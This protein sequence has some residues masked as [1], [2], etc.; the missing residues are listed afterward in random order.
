[1]TVRTAVLS[2]SSGKS[3][4]PDRSFRAITAVFAVSVV[5]LLALLAI[6]LGASSSL[7]WSTFGLGFLTGTTWDPVTSTYAALPYIVG[8]LASSL[9]AL[10]IAAPLGLLTA[11]YLM[12]KRGAAYHDLGPDHFQRTERSHLAARLARKLGELGFDVTLTQRAA[13]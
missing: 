6:Q 13:T 5:V 3:R 4:L 10:L 2:V 9:L 8:T 12:L 11:I 7:A 1:M